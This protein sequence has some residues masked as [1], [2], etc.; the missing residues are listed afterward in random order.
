MDGIPDL[1]DWKV[2]LSVPDTAYFSISTALDLPNQRVITSDVDRTRTG[3]LDSS[4]KIQLELLLTFYCKEYNTS[5]KQGMN[6]IMAPFLLMS[7]QGLPLHMVYLF[8]K[9]FIHTYLPTMFVDHEFRPLQAM[10]LLFRLLLRYHEPRISSFF[11]VNSISPEL[12]VTSWFLTIYAAKINQISVLYTLWQEIISEKDL[13]FPLFIGIALLQQFKTLIVTSQ[14]LTIP[15]V[16]SQIFLDDVQVLSEVLEK[17]RRLKVKM[18]Y[19]MLMQ[20]SKYDIYNLDTIDILLKSLEKEPCLSILPREVLHRAYP[21]VKLCGCK[22]SKCPWCSERGHSVPLVVLDCRTSVEHAAG[23]FPN[24][25][26]IRE[27]AYTNT[28][29]MLDI[30]DQFIPMRGLYHFCLMGSKSHDGIN[31]NLALSCSDESDIVQNMVENLMQTFLLKGFPYLSLLEGGFEKCHEFARHF[32]IG[33]EGHDKSACGV[34]NP[35]GNLTGKNYKSQ[36]SIGLSEIKAEGKRR[37]DKKKSKTNGMNIEN[38]KDENRVSKGEE[39][40]LVTKTEKEMTAN[41][42][43][44][45]VCKKWDNE[46]FSDVDYCIKVSSQWFESEIVQPEQNLQAIKELISTLTNITIIKKNPQIL[47]FKFSER[48]GE[49]NFLMKSCQEAKNCVSQVTKFYQMSKDFL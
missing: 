25:V 33:I 41:E 31:F 16:I 44:V 39:K 35:R 38:Q 30:P 48:N 13:L 47:S 28:E 45:F 19:S 20:I 46:R 18:P 22:E 9:S 36:K 37:G 32:K 26:L 14:D 29:Y 2:L 34:C 24:S 40:E 3:L 5:Y 11:L 17:A 43:F 8:F 6:E 15:H 7:R 4:E 42:M 23:I 49:V 1:E 10:F 27:L 12:F 21:E